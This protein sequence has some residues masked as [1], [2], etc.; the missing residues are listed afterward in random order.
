MMLKQTWFVYLIVGMLLFV[1]PIWAQ[2][3]GGLEFESRIQGLTNDLVS[4]LLPAISILG[5]IYAAMLAA[6]GDEGAKKRML[7]IIFGS[8]VGF[9]APIIIRWFQTAAGG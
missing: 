6:S 2:Y 3:F 4:I 9:L 8:I 1:Y 5:L 7:L